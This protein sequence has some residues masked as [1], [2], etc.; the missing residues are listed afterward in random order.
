[1]FR[2]AGLIDPSPTIFRQ[3]S[4]Y[5]KPMTMKTT[6]DEMTKNQNIARHPR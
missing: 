1:M 5:K 3:V 2:D 4:G 6:P